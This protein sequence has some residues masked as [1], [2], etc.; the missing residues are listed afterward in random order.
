MKEAVSEDLT[1]QTVKGKKSCWGFGEEVKAKEN[2]EERKMELLH[3]P[4]R[5]RGNGILRKMVRET[6][7][8][9][10]SLAYPM[11]V[12]EGNNQKE[13]IPSMPG[14]YRYSVDRMEEKLS[15]WRQE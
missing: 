5:L 10:S 15:F 7:M 4:R 3:R 1:K 2:Q 13:E 12:M 9:K 14:Q 11:F 8:D 6:R